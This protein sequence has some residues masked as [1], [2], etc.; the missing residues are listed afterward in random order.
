MREL[1][2]VTYI[3]PH[4]NPNVSDGTCS[5]SPRPAAFRN[6][7]RSEITS[8]SEGDVPRKSTSCVR[9][10]WGMMSDVSQSQSAESGQDPRLMAMDATP[11][12]TVART[13]A[14][15]DAKANTWNAARCR[16][17]R[18]T[19]Q[20]SATSLSPT[21]SPNAAAI[22]ATASQLAQPWA[23]MH[24][25]QTRVGHYWLST[26]TDETRFCTIRIGDAR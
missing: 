26:E 3:A 8:I 22:A 16:V 18:P 20:H 2:L 17:Q 13:A 5:Q 12:P 6:S 24:Q 7:A 11:Q 4:D 14:A 25:H 21:I 23:S 10:R 9:G 1:R 19:C 15:A